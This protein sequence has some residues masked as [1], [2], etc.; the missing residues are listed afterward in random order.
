MKQLEFFEY[1]E[2][3]KKRVE[4]GNTFQSMILKAFQGKSKESVPS[5]SIDYNGYGRSIFTGN[6]KKQ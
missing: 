5:D 3:R 6:V 4:Q 1:I 2:R